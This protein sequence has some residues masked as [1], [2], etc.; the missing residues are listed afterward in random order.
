MFAFAAG[1]AEVDHGDDFGVGPRT[2]FL[3][4]SEVDAEVYVNGELLPLLPWKMA[5][6]G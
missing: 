4:E 5:T 3:N 2:H 6:I 1:V